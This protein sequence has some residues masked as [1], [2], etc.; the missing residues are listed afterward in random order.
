MLLKIII[1]LLLTNNMKCQTTVASVA[2]CP[3]GY[4][5]YCK[6][7]GFCVVLFGNQISC[8]CPVGYTGKK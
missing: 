5:S 4:S 7:S 1:F 8:T 6:N 3:A 2:P